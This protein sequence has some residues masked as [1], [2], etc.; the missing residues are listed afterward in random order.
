MR[1]AHWQRKILRHSKKIV[2][3]H[4]TSGSPLV[5]CFAVDRESGK[6][7]SQ[8]SDN[9]HACLI[10]A[11][12]PVANTIDIVHWGRTFHAI[13]IADMFDSMNALPMEREQETYYRRDDFSA[14]SP[15]TNSTFKYAM[16][17]QQ[18][19]TGAVNINFF[20]FI[21]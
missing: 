18:N 14:D 21:L 12:D 15:L 3:D 5:T 4:L 19:S 10:T 9:E 16:E 6:P 2:I 11:C 13:P 20:I 7:A 17:P 1:Y 8:Y